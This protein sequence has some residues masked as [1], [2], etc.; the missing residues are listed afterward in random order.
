MGRWEMPS[1]IEPL[2]ANNSIQK[3][4]KYFFQVCL[5]PDIS[6]IIF[7]AKPLRLKIEVINAGHISLALLSTRTSHELLSKSSVFTC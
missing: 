6:K 2:Q 4:L 5:H 7:M 3:F 1:K